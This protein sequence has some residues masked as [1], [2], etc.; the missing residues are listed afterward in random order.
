[1]IGGIPVAASVD[2]FAGQRRGTAQPQAQKK[3]EDPDAIFYDPKT[4]LIVQQYMDGRDTCQREG[5]YWLAESIYRRELKKPWPVSRRLSFDGA[6]GRLEYKSSGRYVR[7]PVPDNNPNKKNPADPNNTSRDQ[8]V[9][10][11]AALGVRIYDPPPVGGQNGQAKTRLQRVRDELERSGYK[12]NADLLEFHK[13]FIKRAF[14]EEP[15]RLNDIRDHLGAVAFRRA[16]K[17]AAKDP[18]DDVGDDLNIAAMFT[19]AAV[20]KPNNETDKIRTDYAKNMGDNY[21]MFLGSYRKE[22]GLE[23]NPKEQYDMSRML[24][25]MKEGINV[26]KWTP[27][28]PRFV[29]AFRW[30]NRAEAGGSP[31]L[32]TLWEPILT[33]WFQ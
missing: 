12:I 2:A 6:I 29:G 26:K 23:W 11:I 22:F 10:I 31:G 20:R 17:A 27:D 5:M 16:A 18:L 4:G 9:P 32:A 28:C 7:N 25:R 33:K 30:Y 1:M 13:E 15:D 8:V 14:D 19:L 24:A 21:G 3:E